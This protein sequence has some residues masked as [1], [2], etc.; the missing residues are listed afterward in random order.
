MFNKLV[1]VLA[2]LITLSIT[3][4]LEFKSDGIECE[5]GTL[6]QRMD[7]S[8]RAHESNDYEIADGK[9]KINNSFIKVIAQMAQS[10][11]SYDVKN[12]LLDDYDGL[13]GKKV[14]DK[15]REDEYF[16]AKNMILSIFW[17]Y[18]GYKEYVNHLFAHYY[19]KSLMTQ[20]LASSCLTA[21]EYV[22]LYV[23]K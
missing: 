5:Y 17:T 6:S 13:V 18:R 1:I 4:K 23:F 19:I 8:K 11:P 14:L 3:T 15:V 9:I 20:R 2:F 12:K 22:L 7:N 10:N 16:E 21:K